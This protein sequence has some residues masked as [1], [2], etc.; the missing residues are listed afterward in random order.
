MLSL[1]RCQEI[2]GDNCPL[3]DS[4]IEMLREQLYTLAQVVLEFPG[5]HRL[6]ADHRT[7]GSKIQSSKKA[8]TTNKSQANLSAV[9]A[10]IQSED[11]YAIEERA[12]IMEFEDGQCRDEAEKAAL[13]A[14]IRE[15]AQTGNRDYIN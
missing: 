8:D 4:E 15:K 6:D 9:L 7:R 2:L 14:R 1:R 12:A 10:M 13:Q 5:G 3:S 11:R